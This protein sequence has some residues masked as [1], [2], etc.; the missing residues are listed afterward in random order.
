MTK[1][2]PIIGWREW[3]QLPE[4]DI[5]WIKAKVDSGARSSS[6]HAPNIEI[7]KRGHKDW[8]RFS[9]APKQRV[10]HPSHEVELEVM[11]FREVKS[12]N[13][14]VTLR[15]VILTRARIH[16]KSFHLEL[17]LADRTEMSFRMLLGREAFRRRFLV[18][19]GRSYLGGRPKKKHKKD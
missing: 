15:P 18:D 8:V 12:S 17:T 13:G 14:E 11:E 9:V 5:K 7:F 2:L 4:L 16:E 10:H 6:I 19:A 3:V 1:H